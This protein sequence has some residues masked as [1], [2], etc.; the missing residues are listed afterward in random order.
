MRQLCT[1]RV[2]NVSHVIKNGTHRTK[3][4]RKCNTELMRTSYKDCLRVLRVASVFLQHSESQHHFTQFVSTKYMTLCSKMLSKFIRR[5]VIVAILIVLHY[6]TEERWKVERKLIRFYPRF[7]FS[8][9]AFPDHIIIEQFRCV[10]QDF[11]SGLMCLT[12]DLQG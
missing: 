10:S 11:F 5:K 1:N 9:N 2:R 7:E 6:L 8:L 4:V 12:V 3:L